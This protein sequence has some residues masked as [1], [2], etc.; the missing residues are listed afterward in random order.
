MR[1]TI[2]DLDYYYAKDKRNCYN[3]DAMRI[4]SFHKQSGDY[5]NFVR[6]ED[7]IRRP[8]DLYYIIKEKSTTPNAPLDNGNKNV[9]AQ[10]SSPCDKSPPKEQGNCQKSL[11]RCGRVSSYVK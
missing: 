10:K 11:F 2:W 8:Y 1:V 6:T 3:V 5:V 9:N 4:S 7:D